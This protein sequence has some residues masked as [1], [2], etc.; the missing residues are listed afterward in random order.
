[1]MLPITFLLLL[2]V[3]LGDPSTTTDGNGG[4]GGNG[5]D[6]PQGYGEASTNQ[7]VA[8]EGMT[9]TLIINVVAF[10]VFLF[11]FE[12]NRSYKQI[13]L[14]RCVKRFTVR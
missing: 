6:D 11:I 7:T 13:F 10:I 4:G 5:A 1:M 8:T 14:K 3:A 12:T 9:T 2:A